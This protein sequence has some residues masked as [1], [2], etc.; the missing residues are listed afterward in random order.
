MIAAGKGCSA[1]G[2][3]RMQCCGG[4]LGVTDPCKY[5]IHVAK[6]ASLQ[7]DG[8]HVLSHLERIQQMDHLLISLLYFDGNIIKKAYANTSY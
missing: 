8:S 7:A 1:V 5:W 6:Y 3:N 2:G 4:G